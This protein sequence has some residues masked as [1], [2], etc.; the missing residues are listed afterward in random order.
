MILVPRFSVPGWSEV[1]SVER[2]EL[3]K[4]LTRLEISMIE[5][6]MRDYYAQRA[7]TLEQIYQHPERQQD[8]LD[9]Q[10]RIADLLKNHKVIEAACGTGYWTEK[11]APSA[12]SVYATDV[13]QVMLDIA[14]T[15]SYPS[16]KVHFGIADVF[17]LPEAKAGAY[18]A[19]FAGFLW[20]HI[21]REQQTDLLA[22]LSRGAGKGSLLVLI[23]NIYVEGISTPIA[24]T[25]AE[26]NT[27]QLRTQEDGSRVEIVK[28]FPTDSALRKKFAPA[29]RDIRIYRNEHYWLLSCI[30]K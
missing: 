1:M 25:D 19:C 13:N 18:T 12:E 5:N 27:Y 10:Q 3:L 30:L 7:N 9:M 21:K 22:K 2:D 15:K 11:Y 29:V 6:T 24:R 17:D 16:D 26:G 28:N 8:L 23:D 4:N 14:Q 20:S